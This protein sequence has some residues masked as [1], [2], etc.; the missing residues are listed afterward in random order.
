MPPRPMQSV[1]ARVRET[2]FSYLVSGEGP[3]VVIFHG[4]P[5]AK[6]DLKPI[7]EKLVTDGYRVFSI[8]RAGHGNSEEFHPDVIKNS[9]IDAEIYQELIKKITGSKPFLIGYSFGGFVALKIAA[10]FPDLVSGVVLLSP[11]VVPSDPKEGPSYLP[12]IAKNA[13]LGTILGMIVPHF[14]KGK[15][16]THLINEFLPQ[17]IPDSLLEEKL[18]NFGAFDKIIVTLTDK[19]M[20]LKSRNELD[21]LLPKIS[22]PIFVVGGKEDKVCDQEIQWEKIS[23]AIPHAVREMVS[24]HG[25]GFPF[26]NSGI[27][28]KLISGFLAKNVN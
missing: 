18:R 15:L 2:T 11:Y 23:K 25:H 7:G 20:M 13:F 8:D 4:N 16:K 12:D 27:V 14:A 19:N 9:W 26:T 3:S 24:E 10:K 22:C 1:T 6:K 28:T 21:T 5:G 17:T